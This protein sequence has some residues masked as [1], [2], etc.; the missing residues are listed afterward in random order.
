M[1][2]PG[3][4]TEAD[5]F[6]NNLDNKNYPWKFMDSMA[7]QGAAAMERVGLPFTGALPSWRNASG[8]TP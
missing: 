6:I 1:C 7:L 8:G 4:D 5:T 3:A 2:S